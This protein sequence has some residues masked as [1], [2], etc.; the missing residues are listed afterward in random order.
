MNIT[1]E[2]I[3]KKYNREWIFNEIN[4]ELESPISYVIS[5][6]NGSGKST[7][8]KLISGFITP[9]KGKIIYKEQKIVTSD[10]IFA[11]VSY[12][13][14]YISVFEDYNIKELFDFYTKFKDLKNNI[15]YK[16]FI[17][18]IELSHTKEKA[19]K[20]FSSG[21]KQRV[22][23]GL[24]IL[25]DTP[26]LLLDEP[27]SNL[28]SKAINWYKNLIKNNID[29]RLVFVASNNQKDEF[30]FCEKEIRIEDYKK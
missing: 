18:L 5:G 9:T 2:N 13:S 24:A 25:S 15:N 22:K 26:L 11:K 23:L 14:P 16:D 10:E 27:T 8:L 17:E 7:L 6:G 1:L 21:M 12:T 30:F 19:I 4:L 28:D 20:H 29:N 3:G